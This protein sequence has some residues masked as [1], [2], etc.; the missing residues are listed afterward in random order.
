LTDQVIPDEEFEKAF[1]QL[2]P[3]TEDEEPKAADPK[4]EEPEL[5]A[6][7]DEEQEVSDEVAPTE[8]PQDEAP[9]PTEETP[10]PPPAPEPEAAPQAYERLQ[11]LLERDPSLADHIGAWERG[12]AVLVPRTYAEQLQQ[13]ELQRQQLQQQQPQQ[14]ETGFYDDPEGYVRRLEET[15]TGLQSQITER[16][17]AA[18]QAAL[19]QNAQ[20][21]ESFAS[22]FRSKHP[23]LD[24]DQWEELTNEVT[25]SGRVLRGVQSHGDR[26]RALREAFEREHR[27]LYP[28]PSQEEVIKAQR[29][30]RRAGA[31]ASSP[32]PAQRLAPVEVPKTKQ[33]R[34]QAAADYIR[35]L[36]QANS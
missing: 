7:E 34:L 21:Y 2:H 17:Q 8:P 3:K 10:S 32:R 13:L 6:V 28:A 35:E 15:L 22:E 16:E 18:Q 24:D 25:L 12:E 31:A 11:R 20:L 36:E 4:A 19:R 29:Q 30:K 14:P 1:A 33:E 26:A 9:E 27:A 23:E 5:E